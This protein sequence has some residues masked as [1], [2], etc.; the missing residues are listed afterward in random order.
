MLSMSPE[1]VRETQPS[2]VATGDSSFTEKLVSRSCEVIE[3]PPL[4]ICE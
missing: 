4:R 1:T 3:A 2:A